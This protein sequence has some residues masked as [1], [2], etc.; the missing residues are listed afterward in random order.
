[1]DILGMAKFNPKIVVG[2]VGERLSGKG[3]V[4][5]Y[6]SKKY[7]FKVLKF[8]ETIDKILEVLH[9][10]NSR[11]NEANVIGG[12]RERF[13][14]GVLAEA[15]LG[16]INAKKY[17]KV[18]VDGLRHPAELEKMR[19]L[20]NFVLVYITANLKTRY[21]RGLKRDQKAGE[22]KLS[23]DEF[24]NESRLA[25]EIYIDRLGKKAKV[26]L[27]N[28]GTLPQLYKQVDQKIRILINGNKS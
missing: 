19:R 27:I 2:I 28:E 6:L 18:V 16:E 14:G 7:K 1:V 24:K 23:Y 3:Q 15:L 10:P 9:L 11:A 13:G 25:T 21:Q 22:S 8:S 26:K 4:A 12:I 17:K 20:P 5:A